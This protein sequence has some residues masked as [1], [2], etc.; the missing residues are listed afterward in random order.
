MFR[1]VFLVVLGLSGFYVAWP[2]WT[3]WQLRQAIETRD[4]RLLESKVDFPA[5]RDSLRPFVGAQ[6]EKHI[7]AQIQQAGGG[8]TG[9]LVGGVL[10]GDMKKQL[11]PRL[12]DQVLATMVT[13]QMVIRVVEEGANAAALQKVIAEQM[14]KVGGAIPGMPPAGSSGGGGLQIPGG[15]GQILGKAGI[16]GVP[17]LGGGAPA[18]APQPAPAPPQQASTR[19]PIGLGNLK[20]FAFDGPLAF[21]VSVARDASATKPDLTA[22]MSFQ[23][24]DW[25][26]SRLVPH[27]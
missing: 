14:Q 7:D 15:L 10:A 27:L 16:P 5:V 13:P 24:M 1:F 19:Q 9:G 22:G 21:S 6:I 3:G 18:P 2:A 17:G 11:V 8:G 4:A 20:G 23:G 12:T 25:K 26:L